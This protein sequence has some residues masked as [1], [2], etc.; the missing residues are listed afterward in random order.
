M[1][2]RGKGS[3]VA[4][5][6][7]NVAIWSSNRGS[8]SKRIERDG[9]GGIKKLPPRCTSPDTVEVLP[10]AS[11]GALAQIHGG[12]NPNQFVTYGIPELASGSVITKAAYEKRGEPTGTVTRTKDHVSWPPGRGF[13]VC[14]YDPNP[15]F[16]PM[17]REALMAALGQ[18]M[19]L[20][21]VGTLWSVS[22]GSCICEAETGAELRGI[23]GQHVTFMVEDARDIPRAMKVLFKRLW[24]AGHGWILV[25]GAG[26]LLPRAPVDLALAQPNQPVFVANADCGPGLDQRRPDPIVKPGPALDTRAALSELTEEEERKYRALVVEAKQQAM[27]ASHRKREEWVRARIE[28]GVDEADART[29]AESLSSGHGSLYGT[30]VLTVLEVGKELEVTVDD[31]LADPERYHE[32]RTLDPVEPDYRGGGQRGILYTKDCRYPMLHSQAHGGTTYR[33]GHSADD[34]SAQPWA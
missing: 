17:S 10:V 1:S 31:V 27:P 2:G 13:M 9:N 5:A 24:L 34:F 6:L 33:L 3:R 26:G 32:A 20:E 23:R 15:A 22:S 18:A 14:D 7:G 28:Q 8:L 30:H 21:G 11:L 29:T 19:N 16:P 4:P 25:A 12:L